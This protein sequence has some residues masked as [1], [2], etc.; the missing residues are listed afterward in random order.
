M[1][2][3]VYL[4]CNA[5][6]PCDPRVVERM[7]PLFAGCFANPTSVGHRPGREAASRLDGARAAVARALGA[8]AASEVVFTSGAT[9]ANHLALHGLTA[10]FAGSRRRVVSQVTEH[11][12]V[13]ESL[14]RLEQ[15][16]WEVV[17]VGVDPRGT[18][19]LEELADALT[20]GTALVSLMLANNETGAL[21]PVAEAAGLAHR[22]GALLHCDGAQGPGKVPVLVAELGVD[23]LS[24]SAHKVYG[25]KGIGA[26][27]VGGLGHRTRLEP[28]LPGGG[29][30]RGLRSGTPNLPG[31]VGLATALEL[32]A[33][34]VREEGPR[35][36]AL[37]D[38]LERAVLG[39]LDEVAVNGPEGA[40]LPN[41]SSLTFGGL[42]GAALLAA[43]DDLAV[44]SGSACTSGRAEPSPV[45]RAMGLPPALAAASL[46]I[47]VGR[48]T[49]EDEVDFA[50][51]RIVE[52]VTR[53][54][55][56]R[57]RR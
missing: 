1:Q 30:E 13:L 25:P 47:S 2:T 18:V 19:R 40:R 35:L 8:G 45:L 39:A 23:A 57:R 21:Q 50:A 4:D 33:A 44:S 17:R 24:V 48:F 12:S 54:R 26:L 28:Q 55:A 32:A 7:L 51:R 5:S 16:G 46:R 34:A 27:W 42:D 52:E 49:T 14:A 53:L 36:A 31:A 29:Q 10:P 9:E 37:R 20:P 38:R 11:A 43:L 3:P 15:A 22:A 56:L 6:T 41:T